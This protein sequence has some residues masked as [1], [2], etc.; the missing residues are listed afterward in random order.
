[1]RKTWLLCFWR[2][3]TGRRS[4][5]TA[6]R[7][8]WFFTMGEVYYANP[9]SGL[10][11]QY[12]IL[13]CLNNPGLIF[14]FLATRINFAIIMSNIYGPDLCKKSD[15]RLIVLPQLFDLCWSLYLL[16]HLGC[17]EISKDYFEKKPYLPDALDIIVCCLLASRCKEIFSR[18]NLWT[19]T[20]PHYRVV[21]KKLWLREV[22]LFASY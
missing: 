17:H 21:A 2:N 19:S 8:H 20:V 11:N 6:C 12:S 13:L 3:Q 9:N 15:R 1:M 14:V 10:F 16:L 4:L 22:P 5:W 7:E 18:R